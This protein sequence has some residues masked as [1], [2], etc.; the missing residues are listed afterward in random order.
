LG[1]EKLEIEKRQSWQN[2]I[3][4][5]FNVQRR[6][7]DWYVETAKSWEDLIAVHEKWVLD[8]NFQKVRHV[9]A[10]RT[11]FRERRGWSTTSG[12]RDLPGWET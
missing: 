11:P 8:Y 7:G 4:T 10:S 3:E 2:L 12:S 9:G 1:I 5:A 6:M